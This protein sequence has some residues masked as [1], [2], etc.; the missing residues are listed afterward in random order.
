MVAPTPTPVMGERA[1]SVSRTRGRKLQRIRK[2]ILDGQ[3]LCVDCQAKGRVTEATEIDHIVPLYKG[4]TDTPDNRQPL[5][6][7]CHEDKTRQDM[8]HKHK[9]TTGIDG[10]PVN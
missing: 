6:R 9:Q 10:W 4:G 1:L 5:C 3:P 7:P 2:Q 8:G